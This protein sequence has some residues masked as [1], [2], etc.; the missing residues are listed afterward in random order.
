MSMRA[1]LPSVRS[2]SGRSRQMTRIAVA[3]SALPV[4]ALGLAACGGSGSDTDSSPAGKST[5][6]QSSTPSSANTSTQGQQPSSSDT[7]TTNSPQT[8]K[9]ESVDIGAFCDAVDTAQIA[10]LIG[11]A[12]TQTNDYKPGDTY[13]PLPGQTAKHTGYGCEFG[14]KVVTVGG[15]QHASSSTPSVT[16]II[17]GDPQTQSD[18]KKAF[19]FP[20]KTDAAAFGEPGVEALCDDYS[21]PDVILRGLFGEALITCSVTSEGYK[22][23]ADLAPDAET[24]CTNTV[25]AIASS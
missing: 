8:D 17:Y 21:L 12:I 9:A 19:D 4:A 5:S 15:A 10:S 7:P 2:A 3:L 20:C 13:S 14:G 22:A 18:A 1:L 11:T 25:S 16:L 23:A 24:F 6:S